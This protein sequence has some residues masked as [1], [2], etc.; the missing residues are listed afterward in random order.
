MMCMSHEIQT[1]IQGFAQINSR[2]EEAVYKLNEQE[3]K[4]RVL[5]SQDAKPLPNGDMGQSNNKNNNN[6]G[7]TDNYQSDTIKLNQINSDFNGNELRK[8]FSK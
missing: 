4:G 3:L 7:S 8:H 1:R 5:S 6:E 2:D